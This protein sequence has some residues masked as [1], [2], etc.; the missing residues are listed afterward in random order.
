LKLEIQN[1]SPETLNPKLRYGLRVI[2]DFISDEKIVELLKS[3]PFDYVIDAIETLSHMVYLIFHSIHLGL[4]VVSSM[5]AGGKT[6][7][8]K[9]HITDISKSH[10]CQL[11]RIIRKRLARMGIKKWG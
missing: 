2:N 7:P 5:G 8:Q 9:I 10:N 4:P 3:Q 6:D 1:N 11:A